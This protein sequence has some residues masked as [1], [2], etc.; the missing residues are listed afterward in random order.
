M[1]R[2]DSLTVK[3]GDSVVGSLSLNPT[4]NL[5][6]FEYAPE[7]LRE[8]FSIS[9]LE[10]PL[11]DGLFV[12][13][14]SPFDG[15]FG[16]F[17]DSLPDGYGRFLLDRTLRQQGVSMSALSILDKLSIVG[18]GGMGALAYQPATHIDSEISLLADVARN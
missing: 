5:C 7:W 4:D 13:K 9:P 6:V 12:A 10:L 11:R 14:A 16:I 2:V 8:G 18:N 17:E 15:G 3:F 1:K